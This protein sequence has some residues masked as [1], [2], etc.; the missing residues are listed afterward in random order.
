MG[1]EVGAELTLPP[2][3][4][5]AVAA[6]LSYTDR[7]DLLAVLAPAIARAIASLRYGFAAAGGA[8]AEITL[9]A[10]RAEARV[11]TLAA[12]TDTSAF[13]GI[14]QIVRNC[15]Y[16]PEIQI[17]VDVSEASEDIT[18]FVRGSSRV[19]RGP[20]KA[21]GVYVDREL[22]RRASA[23]IH[24]FQSRTATVPLVTMQATVDADAAAGPEV[25]YRFRRGDTAGLSGATDY[26]YRVELEFPG[27][28]DVPVL[29]GKFATANQPAM[30]DDVA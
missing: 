4:A 6:D 11:P 29:S 17:V 15:K 2:A 20:I 28:D 25:Y 8:V 7:G 13:A 19:F 9:G 26:F 14:S 18:G 24:I 10:A 30:R 27:D 5:S 22:V 1:V 16:E 23:H 3:I 21:A 12:T